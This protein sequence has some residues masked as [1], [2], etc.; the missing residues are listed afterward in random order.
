MDG[1]VWLTTATEDGHDY[2]AICVDADT[3]KILHNKKLFHSD[4]PEPLGNNV[5]CYAACR[6]PSSPA[7]CTSTSAAIGTACL[8][9]ATGEDDLEARRPALPPLP[10]P[11]VVG[12]AVR[13]P[14]DPHARRRRSAVRRRARQGDRRHRL[15]DRSRRRVERREH[16]RR[17]TR[18]TPHFA[19]DGDFRKAHSTPL[20]VTG[21]TASRKC[22]AAARRPRSPTIRAPARKSGASITTT[23]PSPRGRSIEDGI[24]YIVTG[25]MHPEL[26]A[27]RT[28]GTGDVTESDAVAVAAQ[29]G[30][31]QDGLA[32][33]RRRPDLHGQRRWHRQLHRRGQRRARLDRNASAA[34]SPPRRSTP[35]AASTSATRTAKPPSSSPA[36]N[37]KS[38][39]PTRSTTASWRRPPPTAERSILRTKTHL[40]RIEDSAN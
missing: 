12:R 28:D 39:P 24:A 8:D 10:R 27:I 26:W 4:E 19:K 21:P 17:D 16:H 32:A 14:G 31:R 23:G 15:E 9:T 34:S 20:I 3:G 25:L 11:V 36:A 18:S 1:Q 30:R 35:T 22:S 40:Y 2:F 38:S 5:N 6:P 13:K 33:S 7:A 29:D 37:S